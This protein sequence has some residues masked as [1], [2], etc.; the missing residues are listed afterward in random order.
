MQNCLALGWKIK[1]ILKILDQFFS[2]TFTNFVWEFQ[3]KLEIS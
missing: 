3:L 1:H 2:I